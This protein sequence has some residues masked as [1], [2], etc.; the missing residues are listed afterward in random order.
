MKKKLYKM[1]S[2]PVRT[3]ELDPK[4]NKPEEKKHFCRQC[5]FLER[6]G[7]H[8]L[9]QSLG[10][11]CVMCTTLYR[12]T[13]AI[14]ALVYTLLPLKGRGSGGGAKGNY[15]ALTSIYRRGT[16]YICDVTNK[17]ATPKLRGQS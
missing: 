15:T 9:H 5:S 4:N 10:S 1:E 7:V 14:S 11:M 3:S 13:K 8:F 2:P 16:Q 6:G 12:K 17:I